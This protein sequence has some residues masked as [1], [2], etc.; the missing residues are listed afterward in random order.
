MAAERVDKQWQKGGLEQYS[1]QAIVGTLAHYGVTVDE[2]S[3]KELTREEYPLQVAHDWHAA[4]KGTGQFSK[5][6]YAAASELFKRAWPDR[7]APLDLA[8]ALAGLIDALEKLLDGAPD[9][10]VGAAFEKVNA[11][12]PKLPAGEALENLMNEVVIQLGEEGAETFDELAERLSKEGH[13]DD[14]RDFAALEEALLPERRGISTAVVSAAAGEKDHAISQVEAVLA[15]AAR[16]HESQVMAVDALIHF[17]DLPKATTAAE[18]LLVKAEQK[19]DFHLG[20]AVCERLGFLYEKGE[21][22][23]EL[24]ALS[25]RARSLADAHEKAHPDHA[26]HHHHG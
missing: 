5:F 8:L 6:P 24:E 2:A 13:L 21:Q 22:W 14:A 12:R 18:A 1:T 23:K 3:F 19:Q 20:L 25:Q 4:W 15:D 16:S 17:E 26:H 7:L 9:A 11:L 10:P